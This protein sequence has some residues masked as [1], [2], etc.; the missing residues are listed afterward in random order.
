MFAKDKKYFETW[1]PDRGVTINIGRNIF[2]SIPMGTLV[3]LADRFALRYMQ[4]KYAMFLGLQN[5][6]KRADGW[7]WEEDWGFPEGVTEESGTHQLWLVEDKKILLDIGSEKYKIISNGS[8]KL[9][10]NKDSKVIRWVHNEANKSVSEQKRLSYVD[11]SE[12]Q[13]AFESNTD[14]RI[15]KLQQKED[16]YLLI[17]NWL[18]VCTPKQ[19][20]LWS[21]GKSLRSEFDRQQYRDFKSELFQKWKNEIISWIDSSSEFSLSLKNAVNRNFS[22]A[23]ERTTFKREVYKYFC[24]LEG[25]NLK[26][27]HRSYDN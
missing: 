14:Y 2:T 10:K 17:E 4:N 8:V 1:H 3:Q 21:F 13:R 7:Q 5:Y 19:S 9:S 12:E 27:W 24:Q 15:E 11:L 26:N 22:Y 20:N 16:L 23:H 6:Y 25:N 18:R